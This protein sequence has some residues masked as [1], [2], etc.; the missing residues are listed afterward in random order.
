MAEYFSHDYDAREDEKIIGLMAETGWAGYGLYWGLV[1]LLYKN[2]GKMRLQ[3]DRIAFAL[4]S[5]PETIKQLIKNFNLFQV[6]NDFFTSKSVKERLKK[7]AAISEAARANAY[8]RWEKEDT[9]A[10]PPQSARNAIKERERKKEKEL[11]EFK[12]EV[13]SFK[14]KYPIEMLDGFIT[15]WTEPNKSKSK[16]RFQ[17]QP[18]WLTSGR[19]AKWH[20]NNFNKSNQSSQ[21]PDQSNFN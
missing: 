15:Y 2:D 9:P 8:K 6:R 21:K 3:Y 7:R 14:E 13:L 4:N 1:E 16:M 20:S 19:L 11:K 17:M 18:T 12:E 10:L 5:H